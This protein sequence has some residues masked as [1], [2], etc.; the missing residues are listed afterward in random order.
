MIFI[1]ILFRGTILAY[2]HNLSIINR[3]HSYNKTR[4]ICAIRHLNLGPKALCIRNVKHFYCW[5]ESVQDA[6]IDPY[7]A[8]K[9]AGCYP[10]HF[11]VEAWRWWPFCSCIIVA[12]YPVW[13]YV[14]HAVGFNSAGVLSSNSINIA[15]RV[16]CQSKMPAVVLL[17]NFNS[18]SHNQWSVRTE[19]VS[20]SRDLKSQLS[21]KNHYVWTDLNSV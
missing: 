4:V 13:E 21:D 18:L 17:I 12:I 15:V 19:Q 16:T 3:A 8:A 7:F 9:C 2:Y 5:A 14:S 11:V 1:F 20:D 6:A 10:N